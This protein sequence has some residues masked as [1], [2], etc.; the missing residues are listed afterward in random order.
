MALRLEPTTFNLPIARRTLIL[1][2]VLVQRVG[3]AVK[4]AGNLAEAQARGL[5]VNIIRSQGEN[6]AILGGARPS[7]GRGQAIKDGFS[8][9]RHHSNTQDRP[10]PPGP[11]QRG[12]AAQ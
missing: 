4:G 9:L 11:G 2:L 1:I 8:Q 5:G 3:P 10:K 7:F 6:F 12:G